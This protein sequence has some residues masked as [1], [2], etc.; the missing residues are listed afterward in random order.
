MSKIDSVLSI[1]EAISLIKPGSRIMVGGFGLSGYPDLLIDALVDS[2]VG[3]LT[4][5]SNDLGSPNV[6]LGRLL[7]NGQIKSLIGNFYNWNPDVAEAYNKGIIDVTLVPQGTFAEAIRAAGAGIPA[8][9]TKTAVGTELAE[10]KETR[11]F[12]GETYIMERAISADF[13]LIK[14]H[15]A[16]RLGNLTYYKTARN[17][18]PIMAMAAEVTIAQVDEILPV[19]KLDP[20]CIVTPHIYVDVL[21]KGDDANGFN[22]T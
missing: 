16:D 22:K 3:D 12:D 17:F 13:A 21:C 19:G 6:G 18:N 10:S 2:G 1:E 9:Y 11:E 8:F 14:A 4:I 5:I 7:T 20:E 15:K